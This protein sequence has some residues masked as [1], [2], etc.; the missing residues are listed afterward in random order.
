MSTTT[1]DSL[2]LVTGRT[3]N[4]SS[5]TDEVHTCEVRVGDFLS[6]PLVTDTIVW[7]VVKITP[8]TLTVRSTTVGGTVHND[9]RDGNPFPVNYAAALTDPHG[10]TKTLRVRGDGTVRMGSHR[11][12]RAMYPT[13]TRGGV[14][15]RKV[16]YR[17]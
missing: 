4:Y 12:A 8:K 16:D 9:H 13:P 2:T 6:E 11:G 3:R 1:P 5:G 17:Y 15:V 14:P 7:E 10:R